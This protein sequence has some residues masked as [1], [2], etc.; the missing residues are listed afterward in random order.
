MSGRIYA[1]L[2][3]IMLMMYILVTLSRKIRLFVVEFMSSRTAAQL[4]HY[5]VKVSK[6]YACRG[7]TVWTILM[8]QECDKV[9]EK[10]PAIEDNTSG[11]REHIRNIEQGVGLVNE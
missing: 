6:L 3:L 8:D 11:T 9:V 1:T 10:M 4:T 2:P 5:L 7:F